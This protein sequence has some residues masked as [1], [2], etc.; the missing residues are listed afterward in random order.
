MKKAIVFMICALLITSIM[1]AKVRYESHL[2]TGGANAAIRVENVE[3]IRD[4]IKAAYPQLIAAVENDSIKRI[5]ELILADFNRIL[6]IYA[7]NPFMQPAPAPTQAAN[8]PVILN[9]SYQIKLNAPEYIS[10]LYFAAYNSP[11]AAHP[12]ELVYTTNIDRESGRRL[13]LGD[14]VRL[15][16]D[17][18]ENFKNWSPVN[19]NKYPEYIIQ[20]IMDYI[21]GLSNED[22]LSGMKAADIIGSGNLLNI[23]SYLTDD[24]L[25]ISIGLPNYLGDH[26]EFEMDYASLSPYLDPLFYRSVVGIHE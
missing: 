18:A 9:I 24:R 10:I 23:F 25:G 7:F 15:D 19:E 22:L 13:T 17:F 8:I 6:Q 14:I 20:G 26:A 1:A 3:Y 12:T 4:G 21:S 11:Y 16:T 5:N 2:Q